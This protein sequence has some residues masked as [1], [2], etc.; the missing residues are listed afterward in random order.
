MNSTVL[1]HTTIRK[2]RTFLLLLATW[3]SHHIKRA[4]LQP[5]W[6]GLLELKAMDVL[7]YRS[8]SVAKP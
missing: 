3:Q 8:V 7:C 5:A 1:K 2:R 4:H 6:E